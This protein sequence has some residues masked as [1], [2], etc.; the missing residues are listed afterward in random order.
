MLFDKNA[1]NGSYHSKFSFTFGAS[2]EKFTIGYWLRRTSTNL[3]ISHFELVENLADGTNASWVKVKGNEYTAAIGSKQSTNS[4]TT[5]STKWS[6]IVITYNNQTGSVATSVDGSP[7][8]MG[9]VDKL[10]LAG[11]NFTVVLGSQHA[12]FH[13]L[14]S[15]VYIREDVLT[16]ATVTDNA[17]KCKADNETSDTKDIVLDWRVMAFQHPRA[18]ASVCGETACPAGRTGANCDQAIGKRVYRL[19]LR[20]LPSARR[21]DI[22][23][24]NR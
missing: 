2:A 7:V 23:K 3:D 24:H 14:I 5:S 22:T 21:I 11:R 8:A 12:T 13:G 18:V 1:V 16:A 19:N 9:T 17:K 20:L 10:S 6:Y 4:I 15:R